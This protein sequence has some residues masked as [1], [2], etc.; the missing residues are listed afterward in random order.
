MVLS[1]NFSMITRSS[2]GREIPAAGMATRLPRRERERLSHREEIILAAR[3]V[4]ARRGYRN[5][6][7]EEIART[8]EFAKGTIY[9]Y[10]ASK[11]EL[12]L[13]ILDLLFAGATRI[14]EEAV[15]VTGTAR[16]KFSSYA[17]NMLRFYRENSDFFQ[18]VMREIYAMEV[19]AYGAHMKLIH[20]RS[21]KISDI[22][23]GALRKDMEGKKIRNLDP[24]K[25]SIM[26]NS[27][28]HSLYMH[29]LNTEPPADLK[30]I[31]NTA[32]MLV[33][34]FFDGV[35]PSHHGRTGRRNHADR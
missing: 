33:S 28:L 32:D 23:S 29:C 17:R 10:F 16:E 19:D 31:D 11:D 1:I 26:F 13:G 12:F 3:M 20:P 8:A 4:F 25:L 35:V 24:S 22:L 21:L 14:A 6:T 34:M 15:V 27:M 2:G 18:I 7:L 5:A 30:E 9:N